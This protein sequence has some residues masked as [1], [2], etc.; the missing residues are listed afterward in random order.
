M[1][2]RRRSLEMDALPHKKQQKVNQQYYSWKLNTNVTVASF[3]KHLD[4]KNF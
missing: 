4:L 3:C 2:M 1:K